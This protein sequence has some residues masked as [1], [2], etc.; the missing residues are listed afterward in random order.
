VKV[1]F[2]CLGN[3]CRSPTAHA[4]FRHKVKEAGLKVETESAGT[5][6]CHEGSKPDNRSVSV[7]KEKGYD[8]SR[9]FSRKVKPGDFG[10]YDLILAMDKDNQANL[11]NICPSEFRHKV[12]LMLEF[13]NS[14]SDYEEVPDPYYGGGSGFKLVLELIED[15]SDGLIEHLKQ[16]NATA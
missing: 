10:Y 6:A 2:V 4:V 16:E 14:F 3:I 15:A 5:S 8:F 9:I 7:G 13:S 11:I 1:L 12:K